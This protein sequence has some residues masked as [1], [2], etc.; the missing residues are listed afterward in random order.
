M[1]RDQC[2]N[3][4]F[5]DAYMAYAA[6]GRIGLFPVEVMGKSIITAAVPALKCDGHSKLIPY[7]EILHGACGWAIHYS[8]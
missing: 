4:I 5:N 3:G 2:P 1:I 7:T 6:H 8:L